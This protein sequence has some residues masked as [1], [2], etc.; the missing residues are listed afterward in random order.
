ME[1]V[2][3]VEDKI[4]RAEEIYQRRRQGDIRQVA[5]VSVNNKK[6]IKLIKKMLIQMLICI[7]IY[8]IIYT[9]QNNKYV[10]SEDFIN[11]T[12]EILS[13]DTNFAEIYNIIKEKIESISQQNQQNQQEQQDQQGQQGIGGAEENTEN[14]KD[15][16]E[17][18]TENSQGDTETQNAEQNGDKV[19]QE[20]EQKLPQG[21]Q[22]IQ[23]V[24]NT[25]SFIRPVE[26]AVSSKYGQR[27]TATGS[28][29]KNHTGVDIAADMG[30]KIKSATDGE[31]V[32]A[33]DQGDYRK[34]FKDS[35][36]K[37]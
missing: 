20:G 10:F 34:T 37:G 3:S 19:N 13:Y 18:N 33:S 36:W 7:A 16:S 1:K 28:V 26:G 22:D 15:T 12:N 25:S 35:N 23:D 6:D 29:P 2:M 11:K 27:D 21:E 17:Q 4:R 9:I 31:V 8:L 14:G 5:K 30:A 32:L 24:K